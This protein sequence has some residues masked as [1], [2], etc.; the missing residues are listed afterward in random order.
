[1]YKLLKAEIKYRNSSLHDFDY[2]WIEKYFSYETIRLVNI[3]RFQ[4]FNEL[5]EPLQKPLVYYANLELTKIKVDTAEK[6][7]MLEN[8]T[9]DL[10]KELKTIYERK[11]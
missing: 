10:F 3:M 1:M 5:L 4:E 8:I 9:Y 2:S 6:I 11:V 7:K